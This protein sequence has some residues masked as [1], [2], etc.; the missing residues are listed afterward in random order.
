MFHSVKPMS[1]CE[2]EE[3][4]DGN[5]SSVKSEKN[6]CQVGPDP[7]FSI[8]G[9]EQAQESLTH[10]WWLWHWFNHNLMDLVPALLLLLLV[11][12]SFMVVLMFFFVFVDSSF[13]IFVSFLMVVV[14]MMVFVMMMM[15]H[16]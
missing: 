1:W 3:E 13:V 4:D 2:E 7:E 15:S 8:L 9:T 10:C 14:F 5:T 11:V 6:T 16:T 12:S